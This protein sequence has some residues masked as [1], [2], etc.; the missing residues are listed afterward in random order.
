MGHLKDG[1]WRGHGVESF[2]TG[3]VL[4]VSN[5]SSH[6]TKR[7]YTQHTRT[8]NTA[9]KSSNFKLERQHTSA[10]KGQLGTWKLDDEFWSASFPRSYRFKDG[11]V[12]TPCLLKPATSSEA[13]C[14]STISKAHVCTMQLHG[15]FRQLPRCDSMKTGSWKSLQC[16]VLGKY[17][18]QIWL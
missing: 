7:T 10:S 11:D 8:H 4:G 1:S 17:C 16:Y 13:P 9:P 15:A 18:L 12:P 3:D 5:T 14:S 6:V 2:H